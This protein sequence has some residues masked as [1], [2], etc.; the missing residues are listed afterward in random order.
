MDLDPVL[1]AA[2]CRRCLPFP[3]IVRKEGLLDERTESPCYGNRP[4]CLFLS[5]NL[6]DFNSCR[7]F[8]HVFDQAQD[9]ALVLA[10]GPKHANP[11]TAL[12][13]DSTC[14]MPLTHIPPCVRHPYWRCPILTLFSFSS[15][16]RTK[17]SRRTSFRRPRGTQGMAGQP[18]TRPLTTFPTCAFEQCRS[19]A[20]SARLNK[21]KSLIIS[22][23]GESSLMLL[24]GR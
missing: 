3:R 2:L 6:G 21:S 20:T 15:I 9:A 11:A 10:I 4:L 16:H 18:R 8:G 1:R 17:D 24:T 13:L 14:L 22:N 12:L 19:F 5:Y 7:G 23:L